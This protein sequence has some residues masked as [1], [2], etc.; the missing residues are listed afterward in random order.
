MTVQVGKYIATYLLEIPEKKQLERGGG[1]R[2]KTQEY[3]SNG[4]PLTQFYWVTIMAKM[5]PSVLMEEKIKS[6]I[7]Y[8]WDKFDLWHQCHTQ[9]YEIYITQGFSLCSRYFAG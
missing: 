5:T 1:Q 7:K 4:M 2:F 8:M 6:Y 3:L 9:D